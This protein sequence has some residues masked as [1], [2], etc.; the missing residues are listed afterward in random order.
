MTTMAIFFYHAEIGRCMNMRKES[1]NASSERLSAPIMPV[2]LLVWLHIWYAAE[3]M[4]SISHLNF[5]VALESRSFRNWLYVDILSCLPYGV[6]LWRVSQGRK[7]MLILWS[8]A[9]LWLSSSHDTTGIMQKPA[10][11]WD[12]IQQYTFTPMMLETKSKRCEKPRTLL[13]RP[14][15]QDSVLEC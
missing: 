13:P 4:H 6:W 11:K 14:R 8:C 10:E 15:T 7:M 5:Q 3:W 12:W 9:V 1:W 2:G